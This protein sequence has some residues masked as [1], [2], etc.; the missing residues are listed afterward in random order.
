VA[1]DPFAYS[2]RL[3]DDRGLFVEVDR[4]WLAYGRVDGDHAVERLAHF[5]DRSDWPSARA[6]R[7][8]VRG[9]LRFMSADVGWPGGGEN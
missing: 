8:F 3:S 1:F 9:L 5:G 4:G 6:L 2:Y 7:S